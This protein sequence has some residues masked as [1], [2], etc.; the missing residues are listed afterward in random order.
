MFNLDASA[1]QNPEIVKMAA[2]MT[3][4]LKDRIK[5]VTVVLKSGDDMPKRSDG[6][7][8]YGYWKSGLREI[9]LW[10]ETDEY[11]VGKTF[12]HEAMH[13]LDTDFLTRA[14]RKSVLALMSPVPTAWADQKIDGV[15]RK[16][17]ALP[18]EVFA[19]YASAAIA[20]L[21]KPAYRS[22]FKRRVEVGKWAILKEL[23]LHR[24]GPPE[25]EEEP[26]DPVPSPPDATAEM[27]TQLRDAEAQVAAAVAAQKAAEHAQAVAE[28]RL[29]KAK[30]LSAEIS[31]L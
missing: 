26:T 16:Y 24:D 27:E 23:V 18:S 8:S 5:P 9:W 19:V 20:G 29:A 1:S 10:D 3:E 21:E 2:T 13:V 15:T 31:L 22:L 30:N 4:A 25:A 7:P 28:E 6:G 17:V 11:P 12:A 14:Q